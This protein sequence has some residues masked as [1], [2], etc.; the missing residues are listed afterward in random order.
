VII[1]TPIDLNRVVKIDKPFTRVFYDLEEIGH[2]KLDEV[3]A[4]FVKNKVKT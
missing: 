4:D 3:L 1:G 2:P